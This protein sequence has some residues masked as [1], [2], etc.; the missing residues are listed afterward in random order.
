VDISTG[1][2]TGAFSDAIDASPASDDA[3]PASTLPASDPVTETPA[4]ASEATPSV[5]ASPESAEAPSTAATIVQPDDDASVTER[6]V[7]TAA[8]TPDQPPA[9]AEAPVPEGETPPAGE[10][11]QWRWQ[12]ILSNTRETTQKE[13]EERVR[14]EYAWTKDLAQA[15]DGERQNLLSWYQVLNTD[16]VTALSQLSQA[17]QA[18]PALRERLQAAT[19]AS[20]SAETPEPEAD[21][22]NN[23]GTLVYSAP[24]LKEWQQ[25][26]QTKLMADM[27]Q[28]LAPLQQAAS[29]A[30]ATRMQTHAWNE[31]NAAINSFREDKDFLSHTQEIKTLIEQ[32][33]RLSALAD[34][35]PK[36]ALDVAW[37]RIYRE[38]VL[39]QKLNGTEAAVLTKLQQK[40]QA[41]SVNPSTPS[42]VTPKKFQS[43]EAGFA[44]ALAHFSETGG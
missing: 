6:S 40:A 36:A 22:Q 7:S 29:Q 35:D 43:G 16:P 19:G 23:D 26:N 12:D 34:R 25:W 20:A 1:D 13:T 24:K 38:K 37:T 3:S 4:S 33:A 18:D 10:P 28:R 5:D 42:T 31:A 15:S 32:D 8:D 17:V 30:E 44:E 39:P 14:Q 21:L 2:M 11:P 9:S 41:G 27:D